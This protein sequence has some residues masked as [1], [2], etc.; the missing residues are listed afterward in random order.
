MKRSAILL[1]SLLVFLSQTGAGHEYRI[2]LILDTDM[3]I[4]DLRALVMLLNQ[5]MA[6]IH[7]IVTS[8]GC[9]SPV[10]GIRQI[11]MLYRQLNLPPPR[12]GAGRNLSQPP[13]PWRVFNTRILAETGESRGPEPGRVEGAPQQIVSV[14]QNS[15]ER[16]VY[17]CLGPLT[18][19]ADAFKKA[20]AIKS[21]ISRVVYYGRPPAPATQS[22]NTGRDPDSARL[23][24]KSGCMIYY[25][26]PATQSISLT[27]ELIQK[28]DVLNTSAARLF[29]RI[30][31]QPAV[32]K[33]LAERHFGIWDELCVMY[34]ADPGLFS[35]TQIRPRI[36]TVNQV[37]S[38]AIDTLYLKMLGNPADF[39]L[40]QRPLVIL[41]DFPGEPSD[42]QSDFSDQVK[43]IL[44]AHGREE[45]KACVLT[46]EFHRHLGIYSIVGAKMG[47][48][49]RELLEAGPDDLK[50]IS[51]AGNA[52]P[53]SCLNDGLQ[54]STGASL[55]R[56]TISVTVPPGGPSP[57][58]EFR[59]RDRR[60]TLQLKKKHQQRIRQDI[61]QAIRQY[62]SL[63]DAYFTRVRQLAI[64][65]WRQWSRSEIFEE[66]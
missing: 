44:K 1:L 34:L 38:G 54:V 15:D 30:H 21:G 61:Q 22:W 18:N 5:D 47:M 39:H 10:Q 50:V 3:G 42:Y 29:Q 23:I 13:P 12:L 40:R 11:H 43:P 7:L 51:L 37:D 62:G 20:P 36:F 66:R 16:L 48:R 45:W 63:T 59:F 57:E 53:L 41:R 14:L 55:G 24:G 26:E 6:R 52:P 58:A 31:N 4:D 32:K 8:D 19:L 35:F 28:V 33:R 64:R 27:E 25:L 17:L 65:Y 49:A 2:P 60:L 9:L 56:G 46:N